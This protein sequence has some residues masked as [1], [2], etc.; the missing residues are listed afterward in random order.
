MLPNDD[1]LVSMRFS[2]QIRLIRDGVLDPKPV[3]GK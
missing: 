2:N 3:D 1:V